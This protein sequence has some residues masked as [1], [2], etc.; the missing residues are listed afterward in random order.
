MAKRIQ[1]ARKRSSQPRDL[2]A[3]TL[4]SG[5]SSG[6]LCFSASADR[7]TGDGATVV[8]VCA[9][10]VGGGASPSLLGLVA[11]S[12][13]RGKCVGVVVFFEAGSSGRLEACRSCATLE[14]PGEL[15]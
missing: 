12:R 13:Y 8:G 2:N 15:Y 9:P 3:E 11:M 10:S 6:T 7:I 1:T 4:F 5:L 14:R